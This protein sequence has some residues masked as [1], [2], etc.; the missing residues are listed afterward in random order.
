M[1]IPALTAAEMREVDRLMIE[2]FGISL[3]QM[4]E[5]A[6]RGLADLA[7]DLYGQGSARDLKVVVLAGSGGNGGGGMAAA[8]HLVNWGAQVQVVLTKPREEIAGVPGRQLA[9]LEKLPVTLRDGE[10]VDQLP[11]ADLILDAIIGYSLR[12]APYGEPA[13]WI[14]LANQREGPLI[15][16]DIPSGLD[17]TRGVVEEPYLRAEAT[18]TLALPKTGLMEPSSRPAVGTLYLADIGVPPSLYRSLGLEVGPL[19]DSSAV[20]KLG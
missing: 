4:M 5:N 3:V 10:Q 18:L 17:A 13:R 7:R 20:I 14:E 15:S 1:K 8:R 6:G 12:G 19:F 16:L 11:K 2:E 9:V